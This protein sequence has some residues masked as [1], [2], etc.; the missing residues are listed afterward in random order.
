MNSRSFSMIFLSFVGGTAPNSASALMT[1]R[2]KQCGL[3]G[4]R[5]CRLHPP[6]L[7]HKDHEKL[8]AQSKPSLQAHHSLYTAKLMP[9]I[10]SLISMSGNHLAI[11]TINMKLQLSESVL[12]IAKFKR[13]IRTRR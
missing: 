1:R 2:L 3:S 13:D 10:E 8:V 11:Y 4:G 12:E 6:T 5:S 9:L 7:F